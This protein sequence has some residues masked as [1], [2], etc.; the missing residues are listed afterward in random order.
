[1]KKGTVTEWVGTFRNKKHPETTVKW[2]ERK[3][4]SDW[5]RP[6]EKLQCM[7]G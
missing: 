4:Y 1:M 6:R 2:G 5:G 7:G 3:I